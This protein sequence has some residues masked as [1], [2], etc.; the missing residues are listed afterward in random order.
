MGVLGVS[1]LV[2]LWEE[3]GWEERGREECVPVEH[4]GY[5]LDLRFRSCDLLRRGELGPAAEEEGHCV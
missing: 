3:R 4:I 5:H 2:R 1:Q